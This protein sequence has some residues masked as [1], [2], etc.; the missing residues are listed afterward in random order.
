MKQIIIALDR[1]SLGL[2]SKVRKKT[3]NTGIANE[4]VSPHAVLIA[5]E[6][7]IKKKKRKK[8][9]QSKYFLP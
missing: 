1:L 2:F 9:K 5:T 3:T 8:R 7:H 4:C 6:L